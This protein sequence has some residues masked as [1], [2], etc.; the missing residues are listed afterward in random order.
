MHGPAALTGRAGKGESPSASAATPASP[1]V[2]ES[3]R[4]LVDHDNALDPGEADHV[5]RWGRGVMAAAAR[6]TAGV[7]CSAARRIRRRAPTPAVISGP[8]SLVARCPDPAR[9]GG[10]AVLGEGNHGGVPRPT[11]L[12]HAVLRDPDH[13]L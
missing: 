1:V 3:P 11:A 8:W 9:V 13:T 12:T 4:A 6:R 7:A 5:E 2:A 10:N